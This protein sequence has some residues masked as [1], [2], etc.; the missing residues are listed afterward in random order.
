MDSAGEPSTRNIMLEPNATFI[1]AKVRQDTRF[2]IIEILKR[3]NVHR[4]DYTEIPPS[5]PGESTIGRFEITIKDSEEVD[6]QRF[7]ASFL[8]GATGYQPPD[9]TLV[10]SRVTFLDNTPEG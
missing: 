6:I 10:V 9:A 4:F 8:R 1:L 2:Q 5:E 7:T 3:Y